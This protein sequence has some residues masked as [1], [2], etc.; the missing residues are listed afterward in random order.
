MIYIELFFAFAAVG[1]FSFGGGYAALP[2]IQDMIV[3]RLGWMTEAEFADV[4]VISEMTPGPIT[5]NA[6]TF[7]G[8]R[9]GGIGGSII[10]TLGFVFPSAVIVTILSIILKKYGNLKVVRDILSIMRPCVI[11]LIAAAG[12][13]MLTDAIGEGSVL[14][15][16]ADIAAVMLFVAALA[17]MRKFKPSP[18]I[19]MSICGALGAVIYG[20]IGI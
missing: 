7:V 19:I 5:I 13:K 8:M 20:V 1:L 18:I 17:V 3:G 16:S 4:M 9:V 14:L 11:G 6:A 10:S 15:P 2:L 12:A